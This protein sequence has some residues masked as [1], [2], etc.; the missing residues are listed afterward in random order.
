MALASSVPP[1]EFTPAGVVVPQA[2]A[3]L[4][5]VQADID[6]AFGGGLN[7]ALETPQGQLAS[8][9]T[10]IIDDKNGQIAYLTNQIDPQYS[11]GRFQDA[12]GRIYFL[13]RK[14]GVPTVVSCT[15]GGAPGTVIPWG[16]LAQDT[17]GNVYQSSHDAVIGPGSTVQVDF[18]NGLPGAIPCGP[19]ELIV[20]VQAISGW[21]TIYN[22][23]AGVAGYLTESR[24]AFEFRRRVSVAINAHGSLGA[25]YGE[26]FAVPDVIDCYATENPTG[27]PVD[28]GATDYTLVAH[29]LYVAVVGGDDAAV[30]RAIWT[31]KD[32]GCDYNGNTTETIIDTD[33]YEYPQPSYEV[34]FMRPAALPILFAVN[35]VNNPALPFDVVRLIK[36]AIIARFNGTDDTDRQRIG[37]TVFASTYY[38]PTAAVS[39]KVSIISILIG[40]SLANLASVPV[41]VDQVPTIADDD[42]T[43]TLV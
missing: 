19:G 43:V 12:I 23:A 25:I 18:E 26:V 10:A 16:A 33:G 15:L 14:P 21:D 32:V 5:G 20:I 3:V 7:S 36:D 28:V 42:I 39:P 1:L 22:A 41:G 6:A 8:S 29:S 40:T 24:A 27:A 37:A 38:G 2:A 17:S 13:E 31:K 4:A 11:S 34:T 30:A 9:E 35:I